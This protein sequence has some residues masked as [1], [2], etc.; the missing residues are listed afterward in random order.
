MHIRIM[1]CSLILT[2]ASH[3]GASL[4][5]ADITPPSQLTTIPATGSAVV[6]LG[7]VEVYFSEDV[8]GVDAADLLINGLPATNVFVVQPSQ[9][10]FQFATPPRG[11]VQVSW[12][13]ANGI[14]DLETNPFAGGSWSYNLDPSLALQQVR[15]NEFMAD[16]ETRLRDED[17]TYQDWIELYNG[18]PIAVNLDGCWLTDTKFPLANWRVPAI[19]M[20]PG[21]YLLIWASSKNRVNLNG[22]LHTNFKISKGGGYLALLSPQ[23]NV[24][25]AFDPYP[26]QRADVSYGRD[27][28]D[29]GTVGYYAGTNVTPRAIN[30]SG[31]SAS[32]FAPDV[33][34]SRDGGTFIDSFDVTLS[35]PSPTAVIRY[36]LVTAATSLGQ[37]ASTVTNVPTATSPIYTG[38]ITINQTTQIRARAFQ[39]GKLPGTPITASYI[40]ISQNLADFTSDVPLVIVHDFGGPA[41]LPN[42]TDVTAVLAAFNS[43]LDRS[44][45]MRKPDLISR[46]GVNDRGSSTAGQPKQHMAV[47][48]WDEFN[49]DTDHELVGL[50]AESDWVFY[51]INGFD[52][53]LMHN[54]VFHWFGRAVGRYAPRTRFVE[55]FFKSGTGAITTNDYRGLYLV[56][57]KIKRN[58]NRVDIE[59]IEVE[60]TNAPSVTGGYI[61]RIDRQNDAGEVGFRPPTVGTVTST[62]EPITYVTPGVEMTTASSNTN[63]PWRAHTNYI[64]S[65]ILNFITN[66]ASPEFTNTVSGY[67]S[68][69]D[70]DSWVDNH[71]GNTICFNVDGYR[72]SG[73]FFKDRN[74]KLEQGPFWDCDRCLGTGGVG[75]QTPQADNR[76]YNPRI[77]RTYT[78]DPANDQGT[79]FFDRST[80]GV[81]WWY[82]LFR[83]IDFWQKYID[84]YQALRTN[85]YSNAKVMAM[86]DGFHDEIREAQVREQNRWAP[87][88]FTYSRAGVQSVTTTAGAFSS[89]YSYNFGPTSV[90]YSGRAVGYYSN[91]VN[92]QKKWLADRMDFMDTNFLAMPVLSVGTS[93]VTNGTTLTILAAAKPGTSIYYT[94]DGTDPR[95]PGGGISPLALSTPGNLTLT[96]TDNVR[97]FARCRNPNHANLTNSTLV[98][99]PPLNSLWSGPVVATYYTKVPPLRITEL[100]YH[101]PKPAAGNTNDQDNFEYI[102]VKNISATPLSLNRFRLRGGVDFDFP[103]TMLPGGSNAVIVRNVAS[104]Q[105][106]YGNGP[107]ILGSY[108]NDNLANDGDRLVLEGSLREPILDFSYRD[109]W[110]PITDGGGFSLQIVNDSLATTNWNMQPGWRPSGVE[111]GTPGANDP[112]VTSVAAVY[113]NEALT[114]TDPA[115][116]DVIELHNPNGSPVDIGDWYLT[117]AF[118]TPKKYRIPF[119]TI[120]PANGYTVFYQSNSFGLGSN[121][122]ALSSKGDEVYLYSGNASGT[123]SGY[124]Q[125]FRFGAQAKGLTF[126]RHVISTREDQFVVQTT[127]TLGSANSGPKV[128]PVAI[129]EINYH[130]PDITYPLN[131]IDNDIDEYIE[132]QNISGVP[133]RLDD[134]ANPANT[135]HL[136]DA[137][138]YNFPSGVII[139]PGGYVL[140]V[141][142]TPTNG[143]VLENFR[144]VN[145]VPPSTPIYG[146]WSGQL[147][148]SK[149]NVELVRPDLPDAPGT[150]TT[151]FV[152]YL[153]ADK[154]DYEDVAPWPIGYADG[155]GASISRINVNSHGNDPAN[156]VAGIKTPGAPLVTAGTS[157]SVVVQPV[158]T[159]G[160]ETFGATFGIAGSGTGPLGYQ[161]LFNGVPIRAPSSP[162][163]IL[164][165]LKLNQAGDY[166]CLVFGPAGITNSASAT[167]TVRQVARITQY[168][169]SRTAY[170]KPDPKAANLPNGTN[171][172]FTISATTIFP[173]LSYQWFFNGTPI[174]GAT[175]TS[176][177]VTNVQLSSEGNYTCAV[178]DGAATVLSS[179]ARLTPWLQPV[180]IQKPTDITVAAGSDFT[181]SVEITGNPAPFAYSWRRNLGSVVVSTNSGSYKTNFITLNTVTALLNLTNNIQSSNFVMRLVV[182]N[183]ANT[184]PGVTTTFNVTVLEDSDRDGIP[185]VV[186][187]GLGMDTNNAADASGDLDLD[188]M[189]NRAEFIAGTD[190]TN[191]LSYLKIET[192][193]TPGTSSV[194]FGGISNH[195]YTVQFTDSL[196][197]GAW[198]KLADIAARATNFTLQIPDPTATTN[199]FYRVATPRQQ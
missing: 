129:T 83:D 76:P 121:G 22:A 65:Y 182:Y 114:N 16:N 103:N 177:T 2:A 135:W 80:V 93:E 5:A 181:A 137:V 48:F 183:D 179:A 6:Q 28:L 144:A 62:P 172:T 197:A 98:G 171:V 166:S 145:G 198:S 86:V 44:S 174:P 58:K 178:T 107:I 67:A 176:L 140:V 124:V 116:G 149:D 193:V 158:D 89:T 30:S 118:E 72:L 33:S 79:D 152:P 147:D 142:F 24:I 40:Q 17:G 162:T 173:P 35:A 54:A 46:M 50:P 189:S 97:L 1:L 191:S 14:S 42:G 100:M 60:N 37:G 82:R 113:I 101:P 25:S 165:G 61:F 4:Q 68:Y 133:V 115:P 192:A 128:G 163:L 159:V 187:Q 88:G 180:I 29:P 56:E 18:S 74:K 102:E 175:D 75:G 53:G 96:I 156:W 85:E 91:E 141:S 36:V 131:S 188:G 81:S 59:R 143:P 84:R 139:P 154:I 170:I 13:A 77:F 138:S 51:G 161:W 160:A 122:F 9:Y 49:L 132:L 108:T 3:L 41:S 106:R 127:P 92:F 95:L 34:F 117:D 19:T 78:T 196:G 195:T 119:G 164:T 136:R 43:D 39:T 87:S 23:T 21:S 69:I 11:A 47:E 38:P 64:Q 27:P 94:L 151:G 185:N 71:I 26:V 125:G 7:Q 12:A 90:V 10:L 134:S 126:G 153:L 130:P 157:P 168:P 169:A 105:A 123:L 63:N 194:Q 112:G 31:G 150:P 109:E 110:Y 167:L 32:D 57:E 199:R 20:S 66:L 184:A 8:Q 111:Q 146:P 120:I 104:F 99:N 155:L 55:V 15:I 52:P 70:V 45:L 186:E 190:P 73:Y 148:N